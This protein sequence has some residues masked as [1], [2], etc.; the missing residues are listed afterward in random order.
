L[1]STRRLADNGGSLIDLRT[2]RYG[3]RANLRDGV[4]ALSR[5]GK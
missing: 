1:L 2:Y 4:N 3:E 5:G